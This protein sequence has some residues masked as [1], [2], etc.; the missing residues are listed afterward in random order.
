MS[1][2]DIS[3]SDSTNRHQLIFFYVRAW[4]SRAPKFERESSRAPNTVSLHGVL[5]ATRTFGSSPSTPRIDY[6][7]FFI[8]V[9]VPRVSLESEGLPGGCGSNAICSQWAD[10]YIM[11]LSVL[12][13]GEKVD[14]PPSIPLIRTPVLFLFSLLAPAQ[15]RSRRSTAPPHTSHR[16][17][18][19]AQAFFHA[20]ALFCRNAP[21]PSLLSSRPNVAW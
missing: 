20:G 13:S 2:P 18:V 17:G 8:Q 14:T 21:I 12:T 15:V 11:P 16:C 6:G 10:R 19:V 1:K 3:R 4:S 7:D 9:F 5:F